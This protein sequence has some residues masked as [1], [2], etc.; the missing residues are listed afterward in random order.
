MKAS[1]PTSPARRG[2]T[3]VELLVVIAII[4]IL[5]SLLMPAVQQAREAARR[6]QCQNNLKQIGLALHN[7]H[8]TH[9]V[10]PPGWVTNFANYCTPNCAD[11]SSW[12]W[13]T[14]ILP[15]LEQGNLSLVI[16]PGS[17]PLSVAQ[18]VAT[19][20]A[21]L[22]RPLPV[23]LCP[24]DSG[25]VINGMRMLLRGSGGSNGA[26]DVVD[27][28]KS[29]TSGVARAS[30][31]GSRGVSTALHA[32]SMNVFG[33]GIFERDSKVAI[34]DLIDG[35]SNIFLATERAYLTPVGGC[36]HGGALWSGTRLFHSAP[37]V[38]DTGPY[39]LVA[40]MAINMNSELPCQ[41]LCPDPFPPNVFFGASSMHSGGANFVLCDGS[42]RFISENVHSYIDPTYPNDTSKWG[43]YQRLAHVS[44]RR[45]LGDF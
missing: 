45:T 30:Y 17:E 18:G 14:M 27:P 16:R 41:S 31:V 44:D 36:N 42:V 8:D 43:T 20:A 35:T 9:K 28:L 15:Q 4:A 1:P 19:K 26:D 11:H 34:A 29:P 21:E 22:Q 39:A 6:T 13:H 24:S 12:S 32:P 23:F 25:P 3:L 10:F 37:C 40:T 7:Y 5:V 33:N 2:F 38:P